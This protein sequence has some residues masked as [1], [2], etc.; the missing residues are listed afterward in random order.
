[1]DIK[2]LHS[3]KMSDAVK[4]HD[5]LNPNLWR[6][7]HLDPAVRKQLIVIAEDFLSNMDN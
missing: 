7:N 6:N 5:K 4:F 1:M 3:F 2:E